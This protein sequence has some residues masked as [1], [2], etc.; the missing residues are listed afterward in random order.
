MEDNTPPN[1]A[2]EQPAP[3]PEPAQAPAS[4][5][6][7]PPPAP[8]SAKPAT[9][10]ALRFAV[11]AVVLAVAAA[12]AAYAG[13]KLSQ[14]VVPASSVTKHDIPLLRIGYT[15]GYSY[16]TYP[17]MR[18]DDMPVEVNMQMFEGL[19]AYR[20]KSVIVPDLATSWTNPDQTTWIFKL[21]HGVKFHTGHIMTARQVVA[22]LSLK[23]TDFADSYGS[24]I[25]TVTAVDDY[26]VKITTDGP[27]PLLAGKLARLWIFDTDSGKTD[28]SMNGTGPYMVKPGTTPSASL[29]DLVAF[30]DYHGGKPHVQELNYISYDGDTATQDILAAAKAGKLDMIDF[31]GMTNIATAEKAGLTLRQQ[32]TDYV[33]FLI[34][35]TL[36]Q[37][38]LQKLAVRQA[39]YQA[40]D[41]AALLKAKGLTGTSASQLVPPSVPGYNPDVTRPKNDPQHSKQ[42][43]AQAGY[44]NGV[45]L[46]FTYFAPVQ[47][48][49]EEVQKELAPAGITLKLDPQTDL[50]AMIHKAVGGQTDLYYQSFGSDL[51]DSSD[52]M[53]ALV[54]DTNTYKNPQLDT[55]Y[56]QLSVTMDSAKRLQLMQQANKMIMDD[57]AVIPMYVP[58]SAYFWLQKPNIHAPQ[59]MMT[60]MMG[61]YF[62]QA[63]SD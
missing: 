9:R 55:L 47:A 22:S 59:Q 41:P 51:I 23:G 13:V 4:Q 14:P 31:Q 29:I 28:D 25:K 15:D 3:A 60:G 46:T 11:I 56:N 30:N 33:A 16:T 57:M 37:G 10:H 5:P 43:L 39:I 45:T 18:S 34:P 8:D 19:T 2:S 7:P 50:K 63:Y 1:S 61:T 12:A 20:D 58:D 54:I 44:P 27:D 6:A 17:H 38:P 53:S 26:T 40:L 24:T 48:L 36:R 62:W 52:V 35:N 32:Q 42:L 49:A 21:R